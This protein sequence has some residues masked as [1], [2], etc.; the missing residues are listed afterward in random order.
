VRATTGAPSRCASQSPVKRFVAPGP[1]IVKHPA[2]RPV[3]FPYADAA[4]AAAPSWRTPTNRSAPASSHSRS[5]SAIPRF[6]WPTM[7]K[8]SVTP[9]ATSVS[10]STSD[11]VRTRGVSR[12]TP[13]QTNP[14]SRTSTSYDSAPSP[15]A[16]PPSIGQ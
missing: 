4:N 11:A 9:Y 5:A 3:S 8:T 1:A 16:D 13:I 12:G 15:N 7:P 10:A 14:S 6:E 2:G